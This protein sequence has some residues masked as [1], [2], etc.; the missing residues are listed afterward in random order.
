[1]AHMSW[2]AFEY[3]TRFE[4]E[5]LPAVLEEFRLAREKLERADYPD[6]TWERDPNFELSTQLQVDILQ[7]EVHEGIIE[8][9]HE[10]FAKAKG[11]KRPKR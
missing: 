4:P 8:E 2:G 10:F 9:F 7:A 5:S 1:M 3:L 6:G 11:Y